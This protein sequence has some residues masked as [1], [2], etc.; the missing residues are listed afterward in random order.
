MYLQQ[1]DILIK[2]IS[3]IPENAKVSTSNI[4]HQGENHAH[5]LTGGNAL[6]FLD[7]DTTY[8]DV[9]SECQLNHDE[10][11]MVIVPPGFYRK[12]IV[13]EYDHWAEEA[14]NIID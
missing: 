13:K 2:Q 8:L 5:K 3:L 6:I 12:E 7:G 9:Q 11:S 4:F 1:G 10:H 14:R